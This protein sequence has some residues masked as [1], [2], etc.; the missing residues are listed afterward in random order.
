MLTHASLLRLVRR[1]DW[2][3]SIDLKDAYFHIPIYPPHR[4]Y[5]R[6]AFEGICYEY[7]VLPFGLSLSPRVFVRCTEAAVAPLR[8]QGIRLATY[9]DDWL[10]LAQSVQLARAHTRVLTLHLQ[11]LGFVLNA[12]KSMLS[13]TQ[14]LTF[15]GLSLD[16]VAFTARLS[17][18]RV[19]SFRACLALFRPGRSVQFRLCLRLLGLMASAIL[20]VRLGR[21]HMRD[22]QLWVASRGLDPVRHGARRLLVTHG[23]TE[24]LRHWRA[25]RFLTQGVSMGAV[26]SRK[27]VTTDASLSGWGGLHEGRF[28]RGLWNVGLRRSHIN[29]LELSAVFLSLKRFLPY[30]S[31]HHVLVRTDNT[32]TVAYINRQGGLRSRRLHMLA[33]RLILW[34]SRR[35]LSLRA[36]YVPGRLNSGADLLSRGAPVYGEWAL[37][38]AVVDQ[39]WARYGR[40]TVDLFASR[41]NAQC[42]RFF[43]LS[44]VDAPLGIDALAHTWPPELLYAFPPLTLIFPTLSR[45]REFGHSLVL[46]APH[47]PAMH[48]LAGGDLSAVVRSALAAPDAQGPADAGPRYGFPSEPG[49]SG[50][51][52]L[53]PEWRGWS[54]VG[55]PRAVIAAVWGARASLSLCV[56]RALWRMSCSCASSTGW[57]RRWLWRTRIECG[58]RLRACGRTRIVAWPFL[59]WALFREVSVQDVCAAA[60]WSRL[61]L[62]FA[63]VGWTSLPR[64]LHARF[65]CPGL[66]SV[67]FSDGWW[68]FDKLV[69]QYGSYHIP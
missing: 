57:L 45:V 24:A 46:I 34:S 44:D 61:S 32:T 16:S 55:L 52:G 25:P 65:C 8:R 47:W 22:F 31:G 18:E 42:A 33:R 62:L 6:F 67:T 12:E 64:A 26:L 3:T 21:L 69:W 23:C 35:L 9:L 49:A 17:E 7:R 68:T 60:S 20:V 37:H 10:V 5:L 14:S 50:P 53:A 28:V 13:P 36:T 1:D 15:L 43:S 2:F 41:E 56:L 54:A 4:K 11:R 40:A 38:P 29:Y 66:N 19:K 63:S 59:S 58:S 51:L 39:I 27:V 48:A 30:L